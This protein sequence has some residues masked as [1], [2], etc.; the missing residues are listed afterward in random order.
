MIQPSG[1]LYHG[2]N[3]FNLPSITNIG[4]VPQIGSNTKDAQSIDKEAEVHL[5]TD[6]KVARKYGDTVVK[7]DP[8]HPGVKGFKKDPHEKKSVTTNVRI[9]PDAIT[10]VEGKD[11]EYVLWAA[12]R[13]DDIIGTTEHGNH[14]AWA[15]SEPHLARDLDS[16][17][18]GRAHIDHK[19][20]TVNLEAYGFDYDSD[21]YGREIMQNAVKYCHAEHGTYGYKITHGYKRLPFREARYVP[22]PYDPSFDH[23]KYHELNKQWLSK[24]H[25]DNPEYEIHTNPSGKEGHDWLRSDSAALSHDQDRYYAPTASVGG[26][27]RHKSSGEHVGQFGFEVT[28]HPGNPKPVAQFNEF[29]RQGSARGA[30]SHSG[31]MTSIASSWLSHVKPHVDRVQVKG[32]WSGGYWH[33]LAKRHKDL[34]WHGLWSSEKDSW[35]S[36]PAGRSESVRDRV[37]RILESRADALL[38]HRKD[39]SQRK[40]TIT[41]DK[42]T[43]NSLDKFFAL[44]HHNPGH[45]ATFGMDFDGDGH[46]VFVVDPPPSGKYAGR[47]KKGE[48]CVS[49]GRWG[50][51]PDESIYPGSNHAGWGTSDG[52]LL[53]V[54]YTGGSH[55]QVAAEHGFADD[56]NGA[57]HN[58][59]NSGWFRFL[60]YKNTLAVDVY[61]PS[62]YKHAANYLM[63]NPKHGPVTLSHN[64]DHF[65]EF[66]TAGHAAGYL[67]RL[68][69][70][71]SEGRYVYHGTSSVY[72]SKISNTGLK[73]GRRKLSSDPSL[74]HVTTDPHIASQEALYTCNGDP[75]TDAPGVGG[76]PVIVKLDRFHPSFRASKPF[77]LDRNYHPAGNDSELH[78]LHAFSVN[79]HIPP[80]AIVSFHS[81]KV[82]SQHPRI[83]KKTYDIGDEI[84]VHENRR[85]SITHH[86]LITQHGYNQVMMTDSHRFGN[87]AQYLHPASGDQITLS[88]RFQKGRQQVRHTADPTDWT[89]RWTH[90]NG[91][92]G[93]T[94]S[95]HTLHSLYQKLSGAR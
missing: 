28:L 19:A 34:S 57:T 50:P 42:D 51:D 79:A 53:H 11:H 47:D 59:L 84:Q 17:Y 3:R 78:L 37:N 55:D 58:A 83:G 76:S 85:A 74:V 10:V 69:N 54:D 63:R 21:S 71:V 18:R 24:W 62:S 93:E 48:V 67:R 25:K 13:H 68:N 7:I 22:N 5:T 94:T 75:H 8:N 12:D 43:L 56:I 26:Y 70:S 15:E 32:D 4:L 44:L 23:G 40:F 95:G 82:V 29:G 72:A 91:R 90:V 87:V 61:H 2:T 36:L 64:D 39:V 41:A 31:V 9:P 1:E 60:Q 45:S 73:P 33:N 30:H 49:E 20:K 35:Y 16:D 92:T 27:V 81:P 65:Q 77:R 14:R 86:S 80:D 6:P 38:K 66:P 89:D 46:Q 52:E 88:K